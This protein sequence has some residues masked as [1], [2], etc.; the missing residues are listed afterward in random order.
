MTRFND[1]P[2]NR[3][4]EKFDSALFSI[5]DAIRRRL[6]PEEY[7]VILLLL[8]LYR[9]KLLNVEVIENI[10]NTSELL[11][12][13]FDKSLDSTALRYRP[14]SAAFDSIDLETLRVILESFEGLKQYIFSDEYPS[15]FD[16][17]LYQLAN[18]K[19]RLGGEYL[20]PKELTKL[21]SNIVSLTPNAKIFNPFAGVAS[22]QSLAK[23]NVSYFG[24]ELN[25]KTWALGTLR[26]WAHNASSQFRYKREESI[27]NWPVAGEKFDLIVTNPPFGL[28][29][30]NL[31]IPGE[32][33]SKYRTVEQ[34]ILDK[35]HENLSENG[36]VITFMS[37]GTLLRQ[38][39]SEH[40]LANLI[41]SNLLD[42]IVSF[43]GGILKHTGIPFAMVILS[44]DNSSANKV[45]FIKADKYVQVD[46]K[47]I[48]VLDYYSLA[49]LIN[50]KLQDSESLRVVDKQQIRDN[51]FDLNI[52]QYFKKEIEVS[53]SE[54]L[55]K[56]KDILKFVRGHRDN[57][58]ETGKYV[59][60][61]D[62][63]DDTVDFVLDD[64]QLEE[65][66]LK[67][68]GAHKVSE[69]CLLIA[70]RWRALKPT[71]FEF[72]GVPIFKSKDILSFVVNESEVDTTYLINELNTE[73]VR[74]QLE[75]L[76]LGTSVVPSIRKDDFLEVSVKI[77]SL[78]EQKAKAQI[79]HELSG[80]IKK[81]QNER[82]S[83]VHGTTI[84]NFNEF[85]SLKHTLGTPRQ[86]YT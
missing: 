4:I 86:K 24:Q 51:D 66:E 62:L 43:P 76:R 38:N 83:L 77:P 84:T 55:V 79:I 44:K 50:G 80:K 52:L 35:S 29:I 5:V 7:D 19:G 2:D 47:G 60:I 1:L 57:F 3:E 26:A 45:R 49:G 23:Q 42:T 48:K 20:Q 40:I 15:L 81:L 75:S 67:R 65:T 12:T 22:F 17:F 61:R 14:V 54:R 18:S 39:G 46:Q 33:I 59:R 6:H 64:S 32:F 30:S 73:Y 85:A 13:V 10:S 56:L 16:S 53:G 11:E 70:T 68:T 74:D 69:S 31:G 36:K 27:Q 58:P 28:K 63:K 82:N 72:K 9:D 25:H 71:L 37:Q 78:L 34:F 41:E 8:S 21:V